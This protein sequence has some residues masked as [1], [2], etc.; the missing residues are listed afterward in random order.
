MFLPVRMEISHVRWLVD[1][2]G[3]RVDKVKE[4]SND[5][6]DSISR[7]DF[8]EAVCPIIVR[9]WW[10]RTRQGCWLLLSE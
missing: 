6:H 3:Q 5:Q 4:E 9:K 2:R 1:T 8:L 7:G 10:E